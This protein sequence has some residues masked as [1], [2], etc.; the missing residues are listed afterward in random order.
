MRLRV[1]LIPKL[2]R[3][4]NDYTGQFAPW[5]WY[6][7]RTRMGDRLTWADAPLGSMYWCITPGSVKAWLK[8]ADNKADADWLE[9]GTWASVGATGSFTDSGGQTV[10]VVNGLVTAISGAGSY[11]YFPTGYFPAGYL[12][13]GMWPT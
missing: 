1:D 4:D 10:T 6:G 8:T 12:P 3:D 13:A 5:W 2:P 11:P 9:L 7:F